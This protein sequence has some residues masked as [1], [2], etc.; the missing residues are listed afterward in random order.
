MDVCMVGRCEL[1][2]RKSVLGL[3]VKIFKCQRK[4]KFYASA[5]PS[6]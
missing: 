3:I 1:V 5:K 4:G 2:I 6:S